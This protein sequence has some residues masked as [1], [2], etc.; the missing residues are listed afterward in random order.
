M[1]AAIVAINAFLAR[2][3][4]GT[5]GSSQ[6]SSSI[7]PVFSLGVESQNAPSAFVAILSMG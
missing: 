3:L 1:I 5:W 4:C 6:W 2:R 7:A